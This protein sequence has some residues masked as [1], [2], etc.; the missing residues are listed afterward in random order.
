MGQKATKTHTAEGQKGVNTNLTLGDPLPSWEINT[1]RS[2]EETNTV[3]KE[4]PAQAQ[5]QEPNN[6]FHI[7][8]NP[9]GIMTFQ[10]AVLRPFMSS[11]M[12]YEDIP[13]RPLMVHVDLQ[14]MPQ[15]IVLSDIH[16]FEGESWTIK[17][18]V[19]QCKML[20]ARPQDEEQIPKQI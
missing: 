12:I 3:L 8:V 18:E 11:K 5:A 9:K 13:N 4:N 19:I 14:S 10:R 2:N 16:G 20:G 17:C 7:V 6:Q 15:F 1:S